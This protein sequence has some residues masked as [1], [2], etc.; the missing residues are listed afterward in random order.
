MLED[1]DTAKGQ[2][3][4][5]DHL[6]YVTLKYT[7]TVDV[8]LNTIQRLIDAME[9]IFDDILEV[10]KKKG[11]IKVMPRTSI[12]KAK[13]IEEVIFKNN[14]KVKD[15]MKMYRS[16]RTLLKGNVSGREEYR[17]NV[18]LIVDKTEVNQEK[19]MEYFVKTKEFYAFSI[20]WAHSQGL[21][22]G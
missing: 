17:K 11:K 14:K 15:W 9:Y 5:V 2:L 22:K 10:A 7:R 13:M 8:I 18:T 1:T 3:Q 21:T 19:L 12:E 16:L 4:R 20:E 6:I